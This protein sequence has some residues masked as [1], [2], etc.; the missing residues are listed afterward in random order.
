[1]AKHTQLQAHSPNGDRLQLTAHDT[2][3]PVLPVV[4]LQGLHEFRPD[5]VDWVTQQTE[6]EA[7]FRRG[8]QNRV[9]GFI[10]SERILGQV[11]GAVIAALGIGCA[12]FLAVSGHELTA[13][14]L[15]GGTLVSIVTVLVTGRGKSGKSAPSA[16]EEDQQA[17]SKR[18][19]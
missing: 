14:V 16:P 12:T 8:R 3:S 2:D 6:K 15:G 18:K 17:S 5:L 10:F 19:K 4:Q 7:E 1:M 13:S 11:V 9:D